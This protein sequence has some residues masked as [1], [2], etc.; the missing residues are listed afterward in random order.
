[1]WPIKI[2]ASRCECPRPRV[3]VATGPRPERA[4]KDRAL[5][6][7]RSPLPRCCHPKPGPG[8][9]SVMRD[10]PSPSPCPTPWPVCASPGWDVVQSWPGAVVPVSEELGLVAPG[11]HGASEH[12]VPL[13]PAAFSLVSW[14]AHRRS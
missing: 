8:S 9:R 10:E 4:V 13:S 1:M 6:G 7:S 2:S 12:A 14:F 5:V 3:S 11:T